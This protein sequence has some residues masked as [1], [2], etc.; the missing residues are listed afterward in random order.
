MELG[1][2]FPDLS[3]IKSVIVITLITT[4]TIREAMNEQLEKLNKS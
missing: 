3:E 4:I 1:I 2:D